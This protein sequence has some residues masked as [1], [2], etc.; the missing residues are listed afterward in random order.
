[1][2]QGVTVVTPNIGI[3]ELVTTLMPMVTADG[4]HGNGRADVL[5]NQGTAAHGLLEPDATWTHW[6]DFVNKVFHFWHLVGPQRRERPKDEPRVK[7][8][9]EP[10]VAVEGPEVPIKGQ[11]LPGAPFQIG[12]HQRANRQS[13]GRVQRYFAY[14]NRQDCRKLKKKN[15]KVRPTGFAAAETRGTGSSGDP[16]I[17]E[18]TG[19]IAIDCSLGERAEA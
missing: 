2:G 6:A 16:P 9:V 7:L 4:L 3:V 8:P 12:P 11:V 5:A 14:L 17:G 13:E 18:A 15:V 10:V 19:G 1:M